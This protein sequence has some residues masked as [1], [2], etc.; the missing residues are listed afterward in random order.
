ML[1]IRQSLQNSLL[2]FNYNVFTIINLDKRVLL[3]NC[4]ALLHLGLQLKIIVDYL[5]QYT[6]NWLSI[7]SMRCQKTVTNALH[8]FPGATFPKDVF[9]LLWS[10]N[11]PKTK[12]KIFNFTM[13]QNGEK[14]QIITFKKLKP[15]NV[16]HFCLIIDEF[17]IKIV[18]DRFSVE[19][20]NPFSTNRTSTVQYL[21]KLTDNTTEL[22]ASFICSNSGQR[23]AFTKAIS[24]TEFYTLRRQGL[25]SSIVVTV[26][27]MGERERE[28]EIAREIESLSGVCG[29]SGFFFPPPFL[30]FSCICKCLIGLCLTDMESGERLASPSSASSSLHMASSSASSSPAPPQAP[31]T[32]CRPAPSPAGSSPLTTC[33]TY[34]HTH[35]HT[36]TN[37][38]THAT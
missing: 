15:E 36:H 20:P 13:I 19:N 6:I 35:K 24:E 23:V 16:W 25:K 7:Y 22:S 31:S 9:K 4:T 8:I 32:K 21:S 1:Y 28:R 30:F 12:P 18:D 37:T 10:N 5:F 27:Q 11:I 2:V 29:T 33:G 3:N 34:T 14:Q 17:I 26:I 38:H